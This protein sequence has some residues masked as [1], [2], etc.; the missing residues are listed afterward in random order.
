MPLVLI[1][2]SL[3]LAAMAGLTLATQPKSDSSI[4]TTKGYSKTSS[5]LVD[6]Y[7]V[8]D[9]MK[10]EVNE[11]IMLSRNADT[12]AVRVCRQL[13]Y[14][15]QALYSAGDV[16]CSGYRDSTVLYGFIGAAGSSGSIDTLYAG[17]KSATL[18]CATVSN[19]GRYLFSRALPE[20]MIA[21]KNIRYN[22]SG[23]V[24]GK[25]DPCGFREII[26]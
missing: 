22:L 1:F 14:E 5:G 17:T 4:A 21:G 23:I 6:G 18:S 19:Y 15:M 7:E 26:F 13:S 16:S 3:V 8:R 25:P 11:Q 2:F 10:T 24:N 12:A 20:K 9:N